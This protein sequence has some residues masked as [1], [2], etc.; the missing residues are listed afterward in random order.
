MSHFDKNDVIFEFL[1]AEIPNHRE[2]IQQIYSAKT[3]NVEN[4]LVYNL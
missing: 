4:N 3:F 1:Q 2:S